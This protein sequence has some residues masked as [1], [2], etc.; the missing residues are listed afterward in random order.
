MTAPFS[1]E[2]ER[3]LCESDDLARSTGRRLSSAHVLLALFT[4]PNQ[5]Q[6]YLREHDINED[7]LL[8]A[9]KH[10]EDDPEGLFEM[11]LERAQRMASGTQAPTTTSLHIL[12]AVSSFKDSAG[13]R[14]MVRAGAD[15][16]RIR[17]RAMSFFVNDELPVRFRVKAGEN[18]GIEA[19]VSRDGPRKRV[20]IGFHPE[21]KPVPRKR[22]SPAPKPKTPRV[23]RQKS[24]Q[25]ALA[26]RLFGNRP[27]PAPKKQ[28]PLVLREHVTPKALQPKPDAPSD[29][30]DVDTQSSA[31]LAPDEHRFDLDPK[32]YPTLTR[33]GRNLC[34]EAA[35]GNL[36]PVIGRDREIQLLVD[37]LNKR[38]AN[39][40]VLIGPPGVGKT[41]VVEGLARLIASDTAAPG[42]EGRV[43]I[44]L[45][46]GRLLSGTSLRGSLAERLVALKD[47]VEAAEGRI[48][49]FMDE[50]HR[51]IGAGSA[52]GG[53]DG[54]Q[55]L[56]PALARGAF[57]CIG[58]TTYDE[59]R[60][61]IDDDPAFGRR[62]QVVRVEEPDIDETI[63]I[64]NGL[65]KQYE[66]HHK[67][68]FAE[69][70]LAAAARLSHRYLTE[71]LNP[72]K[73]LSILD[74]AGSMAQ[75][76]GLEVVTEAI[77]A[78]V[79]GEMARIPSHKLLM[80]DRERFLQM[81]ENLMTTIVGHERNLSRIAHVLRR[82]YAGFITGRPIGSFLFLGPT[83]VGKTETAKALSDFLFHSRDAMT[84]IDM[85]ELTEAHAVARLIGAPPGYVGHDSGGQLTESIRE[86]PY[87]VILLDEIEKA[88]LAV[89]N[90][91]LQLLDEGRL[92]DSRGRVSD[93]SNAVIIMTSNQGSSAFTAEGG[94][95]G[96]G[97]AGKENDRSSLV[98]EAARKGF[99]PELWNRID[100]TLVFQ[101]LTEAQV[102]RIAHLKLSESSR[103]LLE[104]K[105]IAYTATQAVVDFLIDNG[106]YDATLGARPL[107]RA[108]ER[109]VE[110]PIA[111]LILRGDV[112][113]PA[114]V[115]VDVEEGELFF[116]VS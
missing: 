66:E 56:K 87:Q 2:L 79:V 51:W 43:L 82:N 110:G 48:V 4:A 45:E 37:V 25:A 29:K 5:A 93:F 28:K 89:H 90:L 100:E 99:E 71:R 21:L 41:A 78:E 35:K 6:E 26:Q 11:I 116:D 109:Y 65:K 103:R 39:N 58:A 36:D 96:F 47:E 24:D 19:D 107:R 111:E 70:A 1:R 108:L 59:Y 75:R 85:S 74:L 73:A 113:A 63:E 95:V 54:A 3:I 13:Y 97:R 20:S 15:M 106:G 9:L 17:N 40:P 102:E 42:F 86:R 38:R 44:E 18:P 8:E 23:S 14:L 53:D 80:A 104:E 92:T 68:R 55:E 22:R 72:E 84:I 77:I 88:H 30:P 64:L 101:P 12:T 27:K 115:S 83:G 81:E 112:E 33:Y 61:C 10:V 46:A 7:R 49:V 60:K 105:G 114:E 16:A 69:E 31:I 76:L 67:T 94:P 57:P 34:S 62:F 91:L 52:T 98:L 32:A 50:I